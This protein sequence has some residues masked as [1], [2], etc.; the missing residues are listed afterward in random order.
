MRVLIP[1]WRDRVSPLLDVARRF[2]LVNLQGNSEMERREVK[3]DETGLALR[4][5]RMVQLDVQVLIC[6]AIS[7]P[8]EEALASE[9]V[10][11]IPNTCGPVEQVLEAFRLGKLTDK[12]FLMPGC[13][14]E[15]HQ[16]QA[17]R[18]GGNR[19]R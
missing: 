19:E 1:I 11:I 3:I 17:R 9:A 18:G 8:L 10:R 6:G 13:S 2:L 14:R 5:K 7:R 4:C 15:L 16:I 12:A